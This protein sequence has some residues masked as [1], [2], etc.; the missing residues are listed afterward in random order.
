M[1]LYL[2]PGILPITSTASIVY[3]SAGRTPHQDGDAL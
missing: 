3:T 1:I 2:I